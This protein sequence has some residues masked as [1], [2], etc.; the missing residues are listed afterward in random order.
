MNWQLCDVDSTP[1]RTIRQGEG[2]ELL[3]KA[4]ID[5]QARESEHTEEGKTTSGNLAIYWWL[6]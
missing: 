4:I 6:P 3:M 2:I 1:G 5:V